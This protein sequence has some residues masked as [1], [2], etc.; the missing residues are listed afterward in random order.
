MAT[1]DS[2]KFAFI[3]SH[4]GTKKAR[5][6]NVLDNIDWQQLY[7]LVLTI[8]FGYCSAAILKFPHLLLSNQSSLCDWWLTSNTH[9]VK[10]ES[11]KKFFLPFAH[12]LPHSRTCM[13]IKSHC[14]FHSYSI[15]WYKLQPIS[16]ITCVES[17]IS[18]QI[19]CVFSYDFFLK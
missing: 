17:S 13:Y 15:M 4:S 10:W 8:H 19:V 14:H 2:F 12:T 1:R 6:R 5:E 7:V 18:S 11:E 16:H 3:H 9:W